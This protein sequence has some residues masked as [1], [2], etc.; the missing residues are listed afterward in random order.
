MDLGACHVCSARK[1][2]YNG[3]NVASFEH[4]LVEL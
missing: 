3:V 1:S 4:E 2:A